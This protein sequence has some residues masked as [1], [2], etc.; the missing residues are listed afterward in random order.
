M[1]HNDEKLVWRLSD[2]QEEPLEW[3]WPGRIAAGKTT[4]IDG[5]PGEGKSLLTLDLV[6]R[7]TTARP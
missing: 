4:L 3:L 1:P 2:L 7:L 6:A 5:D